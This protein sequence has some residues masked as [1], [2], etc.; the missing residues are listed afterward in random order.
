MVVHGNAEVVEL[1]SAPDYED[2]FAGVGRGERAGPR[3]CVDVNLSI[4]RIKLRE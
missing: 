2:V 1:V 3:V 4:D